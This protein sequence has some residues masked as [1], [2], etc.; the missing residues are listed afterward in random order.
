MTYIFT[1]KDSSANRVEYLQAE[2]VMRAFRVGQEIIKQGNEIIDIRITGSDDSP[3][4]IGEIKQSLIVEDH[5]VKEHT[6]IAQ[7][8]HSD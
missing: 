1:V 8:L 7:V 2:N 6:K 5:W 4:T 3:L